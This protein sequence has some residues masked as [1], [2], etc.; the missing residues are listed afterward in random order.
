MRQISFQFQ[1]VLTPGLENS[2]Y[3][4]RGVLSRLVN[5]NVDWL[6]LGCGH[7]LLPEWMPGWQ[8][9]EAAIIN[10][11]RQVTGIDLDEA[12]LKRHKHIT[13]KLVGDLHHLPLKENSFDLVTANVVLEHI[14]DPSLLLAEIRRVLRPGG[15]FLF[16]TPNLLSYGTLLALLMPQRLKNELALFLQGRKGEDVYPTFYRINTRRRIEDLARRSGFSVTE[17]RMVET[18]AQTYMLGPLVV[19]ELFLIRAMRWSVC[20]NYRTNIIAI[21]MKDY[22]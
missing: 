16:H 2:Q 11:A 21:L 8:E 4:Y 12:A 19:I 10:A 13:R 3:V 6:D 22:E 9:H 20:E 18:S 14:A 1:R 7:Q 17:L 5:R 15:L